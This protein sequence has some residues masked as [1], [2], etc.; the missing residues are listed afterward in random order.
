MFCLASE[1]EG[2]EQMSEQE[3]VIGPWSEDKLDLL[4]KYL[5]AYTNI[6]KGQSWCRNGYHYIDAFSGTGRPRAKDE[7]RYV[8]GSPLVALGIENPF[9]SYLFIELSGWRV[10]SLRERL[11]SKF[12]NRNIEIVEGDC[13][14]VITSRVVP[15]IRFENY[16]R[17][18]IFLDPFSMSVEW[19]TIEAVAQT[20]ALEIFLNFPVMAI[21]RTT[22]LNSPYKL[23]STQ[24]DR[25][26]R[27]WGTEDWR[28]D[29]Y[30]V[31]EDL[32]GEQ[33]LI[34]RERSTAKRLSRLFK[35][36]LKEIF[37]YVTEPLIMSNSRG[38]PIYCLFLAGHNENAARIMRQ[39]FTRYEK[40][41]A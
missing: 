4:K 16:N 35:S 36:R 9:H 40:L 14:D 27:F 28:D 1:S 23:T 17:G 21:N 11:E 20:K 26:T 31:Q 3:D 2:R 8:E 24:M 34:K 7:E 12:P 29:L 6:M 33:V 13:N 25:M 10:Q 18:F 41:G 19:T 15:K 22:L 38:N 5:E 39:I 37:T 30:H 32:F